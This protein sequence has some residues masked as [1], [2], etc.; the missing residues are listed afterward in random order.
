MRRMLPQLDELNRPFWTG[1][2]NGALQIQRCADCGRWQHPPGEACA[3]CHGRV[4][5]FQSTQG[6][7]R[8]ASFTVNHQKWAPDQDVPNVI[9]LIELDEQ[10]GLRLTSTLVGAAPDSVSIG[11][12][13]VVEF[14]QCADVWLPFFRL[15]NPR[16]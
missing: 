5:S 1:G 8:I 16:T 9:V 7:G 3:H 15:L 6:V 4:L 14:Q 2:A 13:V 10:P 12:D 11:Q